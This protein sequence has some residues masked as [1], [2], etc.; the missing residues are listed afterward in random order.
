[1][2]P[3]ALGFIQWPKSKRYVDPETVGQWETPEGLSRVGVFVDPAEEEVRHAVETARLDVVQLHRIDA[4]WTI[5]R[6]EFPGVEFWKALNQDELY[7]YERPTLFDRYLVDS[8]D[9]ET[10]GGTGQ[11]CDWNWA[12]E[13]VEKMPLS[14]L[15][16]GG[17][18][19]DNVAEAIEEVN[20]WGVDIS[21]G[22]EL[23]PGKKD[24][25]KVA[26]FISACRGA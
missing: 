12:R 2:G 19:P 14:V 23:E 10:V 11:A 17:L 16:A 26:A 18:N 9:P 4:D 22:V 24:I 20:P 6:D 7:S 13:L 3:S 25:E 1:M 21:S 15:L 5:D 8:Y